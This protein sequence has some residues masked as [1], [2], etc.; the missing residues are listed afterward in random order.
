MFDFEE[1][2]L[3]KL[4]VHRVGNKSQNEGVIISNELCDIYNEL[5]ENMLKRYFLEPFGK[6]NTIYKFKCDTDFG[7]NEIYLH[8][9]NIFENDEANFYNES[10]VITEYLYEKSTH[11]NIKIGRASCRERV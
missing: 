11:P 10:V 5:T 4:V 7:N 8:V 3:N 2:G 1:A 6:V 9:K